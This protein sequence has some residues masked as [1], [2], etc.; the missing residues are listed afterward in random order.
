[1]ALGDADPLVR[2]MECAALK[3]LLLIECIRLASRRL[4]VLEALAQDMATALLIMVQ[5]SPTR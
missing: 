3:P 4:R 5:P 2:L 1:M